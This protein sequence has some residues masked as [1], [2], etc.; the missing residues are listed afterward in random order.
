MKK[1]NALSIGHPELRRQRGTSQMRLAIAWFDSP[2][3]ESRAASYLAIVIFPVIARFLASL[4][5][6]RV[7]MG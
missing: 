7:K 3:H 1:L 2:Y 6:T 5:M 4:G